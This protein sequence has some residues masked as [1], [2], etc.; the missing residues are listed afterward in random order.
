MIINIH[1]GHNPEGRV[2]CGASGLLNESRENRIVKDK[3]IQKLRKLGHTVYDCTCD[4]GSSQ[5]DVLVKIVSKCNAHDVDIDVSLHL[6]AGGGKGVE[7]LVYSLNNNEKATDCANKICDAI[8][9]LGFRNRGIKPRP[10]LYVLKETRAAAVLVEMCFVD[11]EVDYKLYDA[12]KMADAIVLGITG[13]TAIAESPKPA[14]P[15]EYTTE[16]KIVSAKEFDKRL[17]G[18]YRTI[19]N[20]N[21]RK[22]PGIDN[23]IICTFPS[24]TEVKCYGYYTRVGNT[25]WLVVQGEKNGKTYTGYCSAS[26]LN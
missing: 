2:A 14:K 17:A 4:N 5:S 9:D 22:G 23:L 21:C 3:V 25:K 19:D 15:I 12:E 18:T 7:C 24:G 16:V 10:D 26:Y 13:Q 6:N 8:S 1:A 11:S 20:L